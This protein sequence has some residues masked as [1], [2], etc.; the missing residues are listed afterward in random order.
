MVRCVTPKVFVLFL[1]ISVT[2]SALGLGLGDPAPPLKIAEWVQGAPV[3]LGKDHSKK[4]HM[5]EFW[6]VWCP[7]CKITVPRLS[8]FLRKHKDDLVIVG[9]TAPDLRGNTPQAVKRFVKKQGEDMIYHVALDKDEATTSAYMVESGAVGIPHA[10]VVGRDG[11]IAWM[12]SPLDP[13]LDEVLPQVIEGTYDIEKAKT[14]AEVDRRFESVLLALNMQSPSF[15]WQELLAILKLDP[16]NE[17]A[18]DV[19]G[20]VAR[21]MDDR[22]AFRSWAKSHVAAHRKDVTAMYRL[23]NTLCSISDFAS[24]MP[25]LALEAATAAIE[26]SG[27]RDPDALSAYARALYQIGRLDEAIAMQK[28]AV[29]RAD[30]SQ[31]NAIKSVLGY[32]QRCKELQGRVE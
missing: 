21:Q 11:R 18:L 13:V 2:D 7:P 8:E 14:Q 20:I 19:L 1:L 4:V 28:D 31:R 6:A 25:E 27:R 16:A 24:R 10:F 26:N 30:N 3:D 15:A 17:A 22:V 32:Y 23:A 9:V 5:I 12:G 29:A